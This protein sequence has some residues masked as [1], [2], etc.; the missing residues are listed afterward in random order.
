MKGPTPMTYWTQSYHWHMSVITV[1]RT[2]RRRLQTARRLV[3]Y[4]QAR[5][6]CGAVGRREVGGSRWGGRGGDN[7]WESLLYNGRCTAPT[8]PVCR[9]ATRTRLASPA[10]SLTD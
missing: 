2:A 1:E 8:R 5:L 9:Y 3:A 4:C 10:F 7:V 6:Y